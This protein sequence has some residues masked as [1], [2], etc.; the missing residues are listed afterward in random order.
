MNSL[1][2]VFA[3]YVADLVRRNRK[4]VDNIE[5]F[6]TNN[7]RA[8]LGNKKIDSIKRP[9]IIKLFNEITDRAPFVANRVLGILAAVYNLAVENGIV[10]VNIC[11]GIK[12]NREIERKRYCTT[13]EL[14]NIFEAL[15]EKAK[16]PRNKKSVA[17]IKLL[18][19]SGCRVSEIAKAKWGNLQGN[20]IILK[21]HKT[22]DKDDARKIFLS[23]Q[24]MAII[25][26]L[27]RK[28]D[29]VKIIGINKPNKLWYSIRDQVGCSD[30][31]LHDLRHTFASYA[32]RSKKVS[33]E[34]VGNLLGHK[35]I[36]ST[37][38]YMHIMD[39]TATQNAMDAG[40][41]ISKSIN[42]E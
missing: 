1:D 12:K 14:K 20:F 3:L 16:N 38:R 9:Q 34:E 23:D 2:D 5:S 15:N 29:N 32:F 17:F 4:T 35:S 7:V 8:A 27:E 40:N 41:E 6:Y 28:G 13:D 25:N 31:R 21:E 19:F 42:E 24:A 33:R 22:D 30:I 37:M 10:E 26:S 36:Q 18:I 11:K 39:D